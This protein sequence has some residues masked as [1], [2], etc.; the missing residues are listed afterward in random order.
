MVNQQ[1]L[2]K[3]LFLIATPMT[4]TNEIAYSVS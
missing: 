1:P 3:K 2:L 4:K